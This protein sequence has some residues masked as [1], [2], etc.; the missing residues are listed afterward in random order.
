MRQM[1]QLLALLSDH[2]EAETMVIDL[3]NMGRIDYT[4]ALVLKSVSA[5][6]ERAGLAVDYLNMPPQTRR[7]LG[8]VLEL[9]FPEIGGS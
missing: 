1:R 7:I 8:R 3:G 9:R 4:G 6:A 5:E 2:P